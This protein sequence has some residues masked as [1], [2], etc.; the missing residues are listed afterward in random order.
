M[1]IKLKLEDTIPTTW[2]AL[3][4]P[5]SPYKT[6]STLPLSL[7][8]TEIIHQNKIKIE[9]QILKIHPRRINPQITK[10]RYVDLNP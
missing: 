5:L 2:P 1:L 9:M 4:A 8:P 10:S 7:S 3:V 6:P